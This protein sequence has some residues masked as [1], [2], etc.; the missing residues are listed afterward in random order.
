MKPFHA[1]LLTSF[2]AGLLMG[3]CFLSRAESKLPA[4]ETQLAAAARVNTDY[5]EAELKLTEAQLKYAEEANER[6]GGG[7]YPENLLVQ[8]RLKQRVIRT[9]LD[10]QQKDPPDLQKVL[11][12]KAKVQLERA[13]IERDQEIREGMREL[14]ELAV[15]V[16]ERRLARVESDELQDHEKQQDWEI[17]QLQLE[18]LNIRML[19]ELIRQ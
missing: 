19:L 1:A 7:V 8:L 18:L 9:F 5:A 12:E 16:A 10:E 3:V 13:K 14:R 4:Q 17:A 11:V 15:E 2:A 6:L